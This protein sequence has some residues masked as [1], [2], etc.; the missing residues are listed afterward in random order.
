MSLFR[1]IDYPAILNLLQ[2]VNNLISFKLERLI[3]YVSPNHNALKVTTIENTGL[4]KIIISDVAARMN[5]FEHPC[6]L[7]ATTFLLY[8]FQ[9]S[10]QPYILRIDSREMYRVTRQVEAYIL[11]TSTWGVPLACLGSS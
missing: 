1:S 11:L 9:P 10:L 2:P 4:A 7:V 3:K 8:K 5:N 6:I